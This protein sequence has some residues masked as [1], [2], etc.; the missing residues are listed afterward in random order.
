MA[1]LVITRDKNDPKKFTVELDGAILTGP[2]VSLQA[3]MNPYTL[4]YEY[5]EDEDGR[6]HPAW[7]AGETT[8]T[9]FVNSEPVF[10]TTEHPQMVEDGDMV[11]Y[12]WGGANGVKG[13]L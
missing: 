9:I 10:H 4:P 1:T 12:E 2:G 11:R 5:Y 13:D 6:Q 8:F 3:D 7:R